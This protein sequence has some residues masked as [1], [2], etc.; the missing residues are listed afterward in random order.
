MHFLHTERGKISEKWNYICKE[1]VSC[2]SKEKRKNT[3][4]SFHWIR[5]GGTTLFRKQGGVK[6]LYK[7][8]DIYIGKQEG[9][10][11]W[12]MNKELHEDNK[13]KWKYAI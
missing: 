1:N 7:E 2:S 6:S 3:T 8:F 5:I 12:V 11:Q 13:L 9:I 4:A 10:L